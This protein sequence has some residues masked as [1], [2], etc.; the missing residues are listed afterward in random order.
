MTFQSVMRIERVRSP[1]KSSGNSLLPTGTRLVVNDDRPPAVAM[2]WGDRLGMANHLHNFRVSAGPRSR[3]DRRRRLR[4]AD[5]G[6]LFGFSLVEL[7]QLPL[8][9][10]GVLA[11]ACGFV[12]LN[13]A[14]KRFL[15]I[16]FVVGGNFVFSLL[17][18]F[19][20]GVE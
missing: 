20:S 14:L 16:A 3:W 7:R 8:P 5:S 18:A 13:Q 1:Q 6:F 15:H 10:R 19:V 11:L 4:L 2:K 12:E 17:H 9:A